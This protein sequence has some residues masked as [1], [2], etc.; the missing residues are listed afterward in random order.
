MVRDGQC[1]MGAALVVHYK[2]Y[3]KFGCCNGET[4]IPVA[5][6]GDEIEIEKRHTMIRVDHRRPEDHSKTRHSENSVGR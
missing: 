2:F 4:E 1:E 6:K 3:V 5:N